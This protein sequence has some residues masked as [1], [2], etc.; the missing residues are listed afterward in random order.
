MIYGR[1]NIMVADT[2]LCLG[3][4]Y[5]ITKK[6]QKA[7]SHIK[8]SIDIREKI[9]AP[10]DGLNDSSLIM[11]L[12]DLPDDLLGQHKGLIDCYAELHPLMEKLC[13]KQ[14]QENNCLGVNLTEEECL[15]QMGNI[16]ATMRCWDEAY[17]R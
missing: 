3:N 6:N 4:A 13:I 9:L 14:V 10:Y 16:Y 7:I 2:L 17:E 5:K 12:E 11:C 8:D 15:E 1:E